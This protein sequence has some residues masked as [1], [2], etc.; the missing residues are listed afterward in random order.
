MCPCDS[1]GEKINIIFFGFIDM[2]LKEN[3]MPTNYNL[4]NVHDGFEKTMLI[5]R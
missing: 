4:F 5:T 3:K 1:W 2:R